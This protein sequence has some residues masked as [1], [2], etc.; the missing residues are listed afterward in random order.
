MA[1]GACWSTVAK[2]W[3]LGMFIRMQPNTKNPVAIT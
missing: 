3:Q 1:Q 2:K